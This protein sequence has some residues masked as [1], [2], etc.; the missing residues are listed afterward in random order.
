VCIFAASW[1][2]GTTE[3]ALDAALSAVE[4]RPVACPIPLDC[5]LP[6]IMADDLVVGLLALQ[7]ADAA[8]LTQPEAGYAMA[9]FSFSAQQLRELL[10]KA[11]ATLHDAPHP[12]MATHHATE[13]ILLTPCCCVARAA[14][15][16]PGLVFTE[17]LDESTATFARLWPDSICGEAARR[18]LGFTARSGFE[19]GIAQVVAAHVRRRSAASPTL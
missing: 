17:A 2:G 13:A 6:M 8:Q 15:L 10:G 11:L 18:D 4:G 19:E 1:G 9:G 5:M 14:K 12:P 16:C 7:D 3:Y